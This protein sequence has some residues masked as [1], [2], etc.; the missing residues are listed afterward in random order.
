MGIVKLFMFKRNGLIVCMGRKVIF[1]N[2]TL[3]SVIEELLTLCAKERGM[4]A[5]A[6]ELFVF[7]DVACKHIVTKLF[8]LSP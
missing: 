4:L 8:L 2:V 6:I 5:A 3:K 7:F 1:V